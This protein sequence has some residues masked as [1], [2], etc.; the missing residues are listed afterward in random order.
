MERS[1]FGA[2]L[3]RVR[4]NII[5]FVSL[6]PISMLMLGSLLLPLPVCCGPNRSVQPK[7]Q[8][9]DPSQK[10]AELTTCGR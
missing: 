1:V 6:L 7:I 5:Q 4:N 8:S 2:L 3:S 10:N 9:L